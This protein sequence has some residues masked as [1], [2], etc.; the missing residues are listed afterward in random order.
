MNPITKTKIADNLNY[1]HFYS[2][3]RMDT[4]PEKERTELESQAKT[5]SVTR[6]STL[7]TEGELPKGVYVL[8]SGKIKVSQLNVDGTVQIFFIYLDLAGF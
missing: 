3:M 6:K 8:L 5:L 1:F 7:Y 2:G 4:I